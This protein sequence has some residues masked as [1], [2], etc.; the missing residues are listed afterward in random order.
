MEMY[1]V[2]FL[3]ILVF[4]FT[5]VAIYK[6]LFQSTYCLHALLEE[7]SVSGALVIV[8]KVS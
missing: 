6:N 2:V 1:G 4:H 8:C 5:S 7:A 3:P